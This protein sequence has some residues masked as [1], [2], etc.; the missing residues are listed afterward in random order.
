MILSLSSS[1]T[2][3]KLHSFFQLHVCHGGV[4]GHLSKNVCVCVCVGVCILVSQSCPT[5]CNPMRPRL[6]CPWNSPG[7]NTGVGCHSLLQGIFLNQAMLSWFLFVYLFLAW[8]VDFFVENWIFKYNDIIILE[9]RFSP[10][11]RACCF[12]FLLW[13]GF[14]LGCV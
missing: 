1:R 3:V 8:L 11:P 5:L 12:M 4:D 7:K 14:I 13:C 9:M 2:Y 10:F 6:L